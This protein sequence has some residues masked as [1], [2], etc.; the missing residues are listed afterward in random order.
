MG[1]LI[2]V[3]CKNQ[4][5]NYFAIMSYKLNDPKITRAWTMYD[6][7]NSVFSLSI[8]ATLFPV[9]FNI[10][11]KTASINAGTYDAINNVSYINVPHHKLFDKFNKTSCFRS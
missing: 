5:N 7:A 10:V 2:L 9:Y 11:S 8:T 4:L 6:W 3:I 1:T